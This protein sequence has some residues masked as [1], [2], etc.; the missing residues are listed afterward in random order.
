M[1]L[2]SCVENKI[3]YLNLRSSNTSGYFYGE[4]GGKRIQVIWRKVTNYR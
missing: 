3:L 4:K 1:C 2:K